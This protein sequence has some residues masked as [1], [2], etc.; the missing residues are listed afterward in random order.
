MKRDWLTVTKKPPKQVL[1]FAPYCIRHEDCS[2]PLENGELICKR[3]DCTNYKLVNGCQVY[4]VISGAEEEGTDIRILEHD[5][6]L[7]SIVKES[8]PDAVVGIACQGHVKRGLALMEKLGIESYGVELN[9]ASCIKL[10]KLV[11]ELDIVEYL[12][13]LQKAKEKPYPLFDPA[14]QEK[15]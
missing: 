3:K 9:T 15:L 12:H 13:A 10:S 6:V 1:V 8:E 5:D 2:A 4:P 11:P 14:H 7:E